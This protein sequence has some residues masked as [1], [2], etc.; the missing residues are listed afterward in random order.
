MDNLWKFMF[1]KIIF[2]GKVSKNAKFLLEKCQKTPKKLANVI[3]NENYDINRAIVLCQDNI[4]IKGVVT[5][6]P[7]YMLM[8]FEPRQMESTIVRFDAFPTIPENNLT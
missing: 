1:T 7:I 6:L 3:M 4:S 8:F 2:V 5:Y